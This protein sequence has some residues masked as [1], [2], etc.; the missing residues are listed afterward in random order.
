MSR[1]QTRARS[2]SVTSPASGWIGEARG[3]QLGQLQQLPVAQQ[4]GHAKIGQA[5]LAGAEELAGAA[6]A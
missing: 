4:V 3:F 6:H 2:A 1:A 5:G